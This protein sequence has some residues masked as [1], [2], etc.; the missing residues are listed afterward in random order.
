MNSNIFEECDLEQNWFAFG[1]KVDDINGFSQSYSFEDVS[2]AFQDKAS[3][4]EE[5]SMHNFIFDDE[6]SHQ[7]IVK[8]RR[9]SEE[10]WSLCEL[11]SQY[12]DAGLFENKVSLSENKEEKLNEQ[13]KSIESE[14]NTNWVSHQSAS[15]KMNSNWYSRNEFSESIEVEAKVKLCLNRKDVVI[16]R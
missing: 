14:V 15:D 4:D 16:K 1:Q 5:I 9:S 2:V 11:Q 3:S 10:L 8:Q 12:D 13:H 6:H 7:E